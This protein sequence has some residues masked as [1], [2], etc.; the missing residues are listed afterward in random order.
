M[1][2]SVLNP[3]AKI[4]GQVY[5]SFTGFNSVSLRQ[6]AAKGGAILVENLQSNF[7]LQNSIFLNNS[8]STSLL[9]GGRGAV[10]I[11]VT[12]FNNQAVTV[13]NCSFVGN[14]AIGPD[15]DFGPNA[16]G[17]S[18]SGG[19]IGCGALGRLVI[20]NSSFIENCVMGYNSVGGA[21]S[22][23]S[24]PTMEVI[25]SDT[26]FSFNYVRGSVDSSIF[27]NPVGVNELG[28]AWSALYAGIGIASVFISV[29][30]T[31]TKTGK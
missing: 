7:T 29:F 5:H 31:W 25:V 19:A 24:Y 6:N 4:G 13:I 27:S 30:T 15:H 22:T 10:N 3:S 8:V 16:P 23:D 2:S 9:N 21:V 18:S 12:F 26:T 28:G 11:P 20:S 1:V 14:Q 17:Q